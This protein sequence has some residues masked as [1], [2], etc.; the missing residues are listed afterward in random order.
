[1]IQRFTSHD[2]ARISRLQPGGWQDIGPFLRFYV[3]SAICRVYKIE[4]KQEIV[5]IGALIFHVKTAWLAHIIVAPE[6][7]RKGLGILMTRHLIDTAEEQGRATQLLIAT[8]MGEP[9]YEKLGFHRSCDYGFYHLP[10][11]AETELPAT[12]RQLKPTDI[13]EIMSLD[14]EASGEDR[15]SLLAAYTDNGLVYPGT[16]G[17]RIH[18]YYMP[19]LAEGLVV[20]VDMEAGRALMKHRLARSDAAPVLP[21]GNHAANRWLKDAGF[22]VKSSVARM[23]RGGDDPLKPDMLFNRIG[24]HLG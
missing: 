5:A 24:G 16:G 7:R 12:V 1:M 11:R 20:A 21:A 22:T 10:P 3:T 6:M 18:G 4:D 23:V 2:L 14:R 9:L 15:A 8:K 19:D 13:P 17:E